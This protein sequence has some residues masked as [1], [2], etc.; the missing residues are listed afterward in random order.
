MTN[1][2]DK[3]AF[4]YIFLKIHRVISFPAQNPEIILNIL[5]ITSYNNKVIASKSVRSISD[6]E[7]HVLHRILWRRVAMSNIIL[8]KC[9]F[10]STCNTIDKITVMPGHSNW[11]CY[12]TH[13]VHSSLWSVRYHN[14][15]PHVHC[16]RAD[17]A[18]HQKHGCCLELDSSDVQLLWWFC[19]QCTLKLIQITAKLWT[20]HRVSLNSWLDNLVNI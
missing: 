1:L 12:S 7:C 15:I 4:E 3:S 11:R 10:P 18:Y 16:D 6:I 19:F 2:T 8:W 20:S 5:S 17:I 13:Y 14:G 9:H